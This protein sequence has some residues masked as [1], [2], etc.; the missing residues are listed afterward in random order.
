MRRQPD[1]RA[2]HLRARNKAVRRHIR[3]NVRIAVILHRQRQRPVVLAARL[4]LHPLRH[5]LHHHRDALHRHVLL[6]KPHD[7]RRRNII[8][9]VCHH[10]DRLPAVLFLHKRRNIHLQNILV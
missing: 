7:D 1:D 8:R 3:R 4:R 2:S 5:L 10:L 6:Q 9:K